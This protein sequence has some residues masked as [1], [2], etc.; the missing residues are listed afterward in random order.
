MKLFPGATRFQRWTMGATFLSV[1][2]YA[3]SQNKQSLV[4]VSKT[5][6]SSPSPGIIA[7]ATIDFPHG[8]V[9]VV[10]IDAPDADLP[11]L[12]AIPSA[13]L[14]GLGF[15]NGGRAR[16]VLLFENGKDAG[17]EGEG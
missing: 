16:R 11:H 15:R 4:E 2:T 7:G 9:R 14:S 13:P 10:G 12:K 6:L 3:I 5:R 8:R 1:A 17:R